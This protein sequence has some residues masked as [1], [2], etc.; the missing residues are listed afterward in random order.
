MEKII[1]SSIACPPEIEN[2]W[3]RWGEEWKHSSDKWN[4]EKRLPN[5]QK[6]NVKK[7]LKEKLLA[8]TGNRCAFCDF[9]PLFEEASETD[10][11]T[12][13]HFLPKDQLLFPEYAYCWMNLFPCCK[14]CNNEKGNQFS[15]LLLLPDA[16]DY[17]FDK[18]FT[19]DGKGQVKFKCERGETTINTFGLNRPM[20]TE[21]RMK[22]ASKYEKMYQISQNAIFDIFPTEEAPYQ[23]FIKRYITEVKPEDLTKNLD[24]LVEDIKNGK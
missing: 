16:D 6:Y 13:E 10:I 17:E 15:E 19:V 23:F 3:Q 14:K 20:L 5:G 21:K 2:N 18:Y 9:Y 22:I 11:D 24:A 8:L 12:S 1:R 7:K 4:W